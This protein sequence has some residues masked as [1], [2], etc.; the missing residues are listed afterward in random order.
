ML[1][2]I[3]TLNFKSLRYLQFVLA[4]AIVTCV[5]DGQLFAQFGGGNGLFLTGGRPVGGVQVDPNGVLQNE[6]VNLTDDIKQQLKRG[7]ANVDADISKPGTRMISLKALEKKM[8]ECKNSGQPFPA[9]VRYFAGLQRVEYVILDKEN[10]DVIL[11]GPGEGFETDEK[12]NVVGK[13]SGSPVVRL[14]DFLVAMRHVNNARQGYGISV[15]IDPTE[16][17]VRNV[18]RL[19]QNYSV[20]SFN[21]NSARE[22]EEACGP[23]KITLTGVPTDSRFSRVL[24]AADYKMKRLA[25]GLEESP[26]FLPSLLAMAQAKNARFNKMTP[27]FWMEADY[28]PVAVSEDKT[29]W[30]LN[31]QGVCAKTEEE[32]MAADGSRKATKPNKFAKK[33]ADEMT[34]N[35][36]KLSATEPVFR[37]LRNMMDLSVVA[38]IIEGEGL[39]K[40]AGLS[41]PAIKGNDTIAIPKWNVPKTVP[42]QCSFA[43]MSRSLMVTTSG[44]VTINS[45]AVAKNTKVDSKLTLDTANSTDR[46]WWNAN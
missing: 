16:Q 30:K 10:N 41:A 9:E 25:M 19:M 23:Q 5:S 36:E 18:Q 46:W 21:K 38:A 32:F 42:T 11:A 4:I 40:S 13:K 6:T 44:G 7:L 34:E 39:M 35:Y 15:S 28:E 43:R 26:E 37:E 33:W 27:R 22:L 1:A 2:E 12:G 45:W 20:R 24:V 14:E 3:K 29:V 17:G 31:G 8:V